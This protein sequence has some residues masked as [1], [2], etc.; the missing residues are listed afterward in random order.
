[1]TTTAG[2]FTRLDTVILR[3]R[4][5]ERARSWYQ[6]KLGLRLS[7]AQDE[8]GIAVFETGGS[9]S[10]TLWRLMPHEELQ[11]SET[12]RAFPIF[13]ADDVER[14]HALLASRGVRVTELWEGGAV[15]GFYFYDA[16]G[17]Q[18]EAVQVVEGV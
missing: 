7:F 4:E 3:V 17:N 15:R 10:L 2:I 1:M 8:A 13:A 16:D 11:E 6:E 14:V 18:L 5:L 9:T 12:A